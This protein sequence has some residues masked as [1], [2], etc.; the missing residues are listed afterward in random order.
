MIFAKPCAKTDI[1]GNVRFQTSGRETETKLEG[2]GAYFIHP[3]E[4]E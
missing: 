2:P 1:E 3:A 4:T